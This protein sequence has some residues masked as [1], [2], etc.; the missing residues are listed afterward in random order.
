MDFYDTYDPYEVTDIDLETF[1][2]LMKDTPD[3]FKS[4]FSTQH[5]YNQITIA[6]QTGMPSPVIL[7]VTYTDQ[8]TERIYIPA[9]I[10]REQ[11][12]TVQHLLIRNQA[13]TSVSLDPLF[14]T[15]DCN[16]T[17]NI[18]PRPIEHNAFEVSPI[19]KPP[20]NPMQETTDE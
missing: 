1:D 12:D 3:K 2:Q 5:Y 18:F 4:F 6:N 15:A 17:N 7:V 8:S 9:D 13:I 10:W 19:S 14:E 20:G 11:N 16:T